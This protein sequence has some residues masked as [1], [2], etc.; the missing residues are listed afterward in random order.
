LCEQPLWLISRLCGSRP[1]RVGESFRE[2]R[3]VWPEETF[4]GIDRDGYLLTLFRAG[5]TESD[6]EEFRRGFAEF[7]L[8]VQPPLAVL[9]FRFGEAAGWET[10]P[11]AWPLS[12]NRPGRYLPA[13]KTAPGT[14]ALLWVSLVNAEDGL[15]EAQRGIVLDPE[16]TR[17]LNEAIRQQ[18]RA[19][20]DPGSYVRAIATLHAD[21]PT[22]A[23][24]VERATVRT[25]TRR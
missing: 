18:A 1:Y 3:T 11:Y 12:S 6:R 14:Q 25:S 16:F 20:F 21:L 17:A 15:I 10:I 2:G 24:I 9:A 5:I 13:A 7:A 4:Y 22:A 23:E 8:V 19:P